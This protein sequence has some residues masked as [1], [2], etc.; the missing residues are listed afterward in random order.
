M[1]TKLTKQ[2]KEA[3]FEHKV[4]DTGQ[5]LVIKQNT[6]ELILKKIEIEVLKH[7]KQQHKNKIFRTRKN[8]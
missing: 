5:P 1:Q 7:N 8:Y 4:K 2:Y 3:K 6:E